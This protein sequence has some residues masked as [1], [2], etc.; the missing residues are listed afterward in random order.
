M[1]LPL[2]DVNVLVAL[3]DP[4]HVD[5]ERAHAWAA[6]GIRT[7]WASCVITE[8][9]FVRVVS[10]PAYP[11]AISVAAAVDLLGQARH[12]A[13]HEYWDCPSSLSDPAIFDTRHLLGHRQITDAYLLALA[14]AHDSAVVTFDRR[15]PL[16]AVRGAE[17][18]HVVSI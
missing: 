2:L 4:D 16:R 18:G 9:G 3:M 6:D 15:M 10:Q 7:G 17:V 11:G 1:S 12:V 14:V 8:N 5:H 13:P